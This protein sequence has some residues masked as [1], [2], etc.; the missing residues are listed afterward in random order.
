MLT[1][2][3][4]SHENEKQLEFSLIVDIFI[5]CRTSTN[6]VLSPTPLHSYEKYRNSSANSHVG[7]I[8]QLNSSEVGDQLTIGGKPDQLTSRGIVLEIDGPF[9]FDS[10]LQVRGVT[11][12]CCYQLP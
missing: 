6:V 11:F 8:N 5:P 1:S 3:G 10:Y 9:H 7:G 12:D 2:L 4:I